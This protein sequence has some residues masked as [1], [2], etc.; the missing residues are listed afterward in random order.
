M[1][2]RL[3]HIKLLLL[4][5]LDMRASNCIED[6]SKKHPYKICL[7]FYTIQTIFTKTQF[8]RIIV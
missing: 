8:P 7:W 6:C 4:E 3:A 2:H 1:H 5:Y